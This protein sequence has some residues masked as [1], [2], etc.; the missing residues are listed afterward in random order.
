MAIDKTVGGSSANSYVDLT[1]ADTYFANHYLSSKTSAWAAL[2]NA[3]KESVLKRACQQLDALRV[4]DVEFGSGALPPQ[5]VERHNY[6]L[7]IHRLEVDQALNFP[8][9]IDLD[10]DLNAFIPQV[11]KDAQCEQAVFLL[12]FDETAIMTRLSGISEETVSAGPVRIRQAFKSD[13][14]M[15]APMAL[16]LMRQFIR[17]TKRMQRA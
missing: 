9:N 8:R 13:G 3:Q 12:A 2:T 6:D 14:S 4:L 1:D 5:L 16:E 10:A 7:L 11:V 15:I 17:P